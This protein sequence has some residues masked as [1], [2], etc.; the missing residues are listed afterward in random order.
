VFLREIEVEQRSAQRGIAPGL[1]HVDELSQEVRA[2]STATS[3]ARDWPVP[4][5][6]RFAWDSD[7]D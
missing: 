6:D 5:G 4:E 7:I 2:G 3:V 1:D